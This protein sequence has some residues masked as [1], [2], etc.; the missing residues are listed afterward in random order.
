M[1]WGWSVVDRP[2][3]FAN[4]GVTPGFL[5]MVQPGTPLILT[6]DPGAAYRSKKKEVLA[7]IEEA[8][9]GGQFI[10]GAN[11]STLEDEFAAWMGGGHAVGVANGTD[12]VELC[13]RA[14]GV[15]EGDCVAIPAHTAVATATAV[16][17]AGAVPVFIDID[18]STFNM[19]PEAL[20]QA[21]G[22]PPSGMRLKAVIPVHL[23][24]RPCDLD[25]LSGIA[26]RHGLAMIEDCSQAHGAVW[27][28]R[29]VGTFGVAA[30][31]SCYP[32][33]NLGALG[34]AGLVFS[35][36]AS[37]AERIRHLRQYGWKTRYLSD[38]V[39]MNSRLDEL[40]AAILRVFLRHLDAEL[41]TRA[42]IATQYRSLIRTR[43]VHLPDEPDQEARHAYHQFAVLSDERDSLHAHLKER[44]ILAG[45]LYPAPIHRQPAY[46][47]IANRWPLDLSNSERV[48]R[49]V[50]CL[51]MHPHLAP[52]DVNR[53]ATAIEQYS[54]PVAMPHR[55]AA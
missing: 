21:C 25:R 2:T 20:E 4:H 35:R 32:T 50:L 48:C 23:Y 14:A 44:G 15:A 29:K 46:V 33:K 45:I 43:A 38:D 12:A 31:F 40:Q 5:I 1:A 49:K 10:L 54:S 22:N 19:A 27:R 42:T 53:I 7:A 55:R 24:G 30:A 34:D 36:N 28:G 13:L 6:S 52:Q 3:V 51:P 11:V 47:E 41:L 37:V 17:R 39:G 8:L 9:D 26:E 18:D 16:V